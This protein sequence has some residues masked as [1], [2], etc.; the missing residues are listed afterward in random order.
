[1]ILNLG[2]ISPNPLLKKQNVYF[3]YHL[4][5]EPHYFSVHPGQQ[6]AQEVLSGVSKE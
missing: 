1:M 3:F 6:G 5:Q 2:L 4:L